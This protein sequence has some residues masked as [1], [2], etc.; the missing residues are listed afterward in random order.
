M[1]FR[2]KAHLLLAYKPDIVVVPECEHPDNLKFKPGV[3]IPTE[4]Q[5]FG[6]N[7]HKG[8]GVFSYS[9]FRFKLSK[10]YNEDIQL[11]APISVTN[12]QF[13]FILFAIWANN[14]NDK[15]GRYI[16]QVWK[17]I[18]HYNKLLDKKPVVL[19]GDFNSNTIW[20]K[21]RREGNHSTVVNRLAEKEIHSVYHS[22]FSQEQGEEKHPTLYMYRKKEK[23]YHID[24]CFVSNNLL[25]HLESVEI[26][27]HDEWCKYSD[28][29]PVIATFSEQMYK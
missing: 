4:I 2:N 16:T 29:V 10:T 3:P 26:G 24:Y 9:D 1:A 15:Q 13:S 22:Y 11:I 25:N 7:K 27:R 8:L 18:H 14:P 17:A 20:D 12:G 5:W 21:P 6:N 23:S 28:H 19:I